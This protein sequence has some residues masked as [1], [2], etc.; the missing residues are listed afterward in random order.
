MK[1]IYSLDECVKQ[2]IVFEV[3]NFSEIAAIAEQLN[4]KT[5]WHYLRSHT[6]WPHWISYEPNDCG[7]MHGSLESYA[8]R[9]CTIVHYEELDIIKM[10]VINNI[11]EEIGI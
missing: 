5:Y 2:K 9:E 10:K 1:K 11:R 4:R 7:D 6:D 8:E 3:N